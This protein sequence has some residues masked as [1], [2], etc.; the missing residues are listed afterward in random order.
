MI[1]WTFITVTYNNSKTLREYWT[2]DLPSWAEWIVVDNASADG[3]AEVA[4]EI[5]A[6]KV[7]RSSENLGFGAAN[8]VGLREA[9]GE[10]IAFTN[11]DVTVDFDSVDAIARSID[12]RGGIVSPQL[13]NPDGSLQPN[14]RGLPTLA[15]KV[16]NRLSDKF[17]MPGYQIFAQPGEEIEVDWFIGAV[18]AGRRSTFVEL[19]GW[20]EKFFLYY[21]DSDIGLRAWRAGFSVRLVG[22]SRW[23]HGWARETTEFKL[24]PWKREF[25]S[26]AKFYGRYPLL[27]G[28]VSLARVFFPRA[29]KNS[30]RLPWNRKTSGSLQ[31]RHNEAS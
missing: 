20:D 11:P 3:T 19:S 23:I 28:P 12:A 6:T 26:M 24:D 1:K 5:G 30:R 8:N 31:T 16:R 21:E 4:T 7:I 15:S 29:K 18:V 2:G 14:G 10:Y 13:I 22:Q 25:A 17:K 27:L 9:S